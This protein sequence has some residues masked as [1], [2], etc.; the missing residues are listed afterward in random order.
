MYRRP[1]GSTRTD[2][3]FPYPT[4]F[5]SH[6]VGE[7]V[8]HERHDAQIPTR[9]AARTLGQQLE[10]R[11]ILGR[12]VR[13]RVLEEASHLVNEQEQATT[14][15]LTHGASEYQDQ[16]GHGPCVDPITGQERGGGFRGGRGGTADLTGDLA[17]RSEERRGGKGGGRQCQT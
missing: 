8:L 3:L 6:L 13:G 1:P 16:V 5:R 17:D 10:D 2:T 7:A 14:G 4:R 11:G 12:H 15:L 9:L